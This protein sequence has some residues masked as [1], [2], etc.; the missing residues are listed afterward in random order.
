MSKKIFIGEPIEN[1]FNIIISNIN[2][3]Q[4]EKLEKLERRFNIFD[5]ERKKKN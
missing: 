3:S 1:D 5:P 4:K 2:D